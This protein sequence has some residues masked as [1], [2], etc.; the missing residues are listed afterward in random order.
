MEK[1]PTPPP[2]PE[3]RQANKKPQRTAALLLSTPKNPIQA[4]TTSAHNRA[5][6]VKK[7]FSTKASL[8]LK[9]KLKPCL[10]QKGQ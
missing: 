1:K 10:G 5:T 4:P 8:S 6:Q 3:K 7:C 9:V 2:P